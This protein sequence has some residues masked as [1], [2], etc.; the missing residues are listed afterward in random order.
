MRINR[1]LPLLV[2]AVLFPMLAIAQAPLTVG[3]NINMVSGQ[4][5][6]DGDPFLRQQNEPSVA[7]SSRNKLHLLSG[8]NDYRTVD[9]PGDFEA[10][11]TGD[12]WMSYFWSTNGGGTWK[13]RLIPGYPQDSSQEGMASPLKGYAAGAD[14]VVRAG[15]HGMFYFSG[16]VFERTENPGSAIFVSRFID[17]NNDEGGDPIRFIDSML[18]DVD[19]TGDRFLDK[20]WIGVD[21]PR[22]GAPTKT[23]TV[24]QRD[25]STV[26]QTVACGNVYVAYASLTG[27]GATLRSEIKLTYSTDCGDSWSDPAPISEVDTLNQG[28]NIAINPN[29]G[30][31]HIGWRRFD[32]VEAF[33]GTP[34]VSC[35][36]AASEWRRK[37]KKKSVAVE[38]PVE[39]IDLGD[40]RL[41]RDR[42]LDLLDEPNKYKAVKLAK[43]LVASKLNLIAGGGQPSDDFDPAEW[44]RT[45]SELV[46]EAD[47]FFRDNPLQDIPGFTD[48][49]LGRDEKKRSNA[50]R[51]ALEENYLGSPE[52]VATSAADP[53]ETGATNAMVAT[54]STDGGSSFAAPVDIPVP[55]GMEQIRTFDQGGTNFSFRTT[56]YPSLAVDGSGR[57][58]MAFAARG[59]G[60]ARP[61]IDTGDSRIVM[62]ISNDGGNSWQEPWPIDDDINQPGH[63][64]KPALLFAGGKLVV[65]FFDLRA[66]VSGLFEQ[67]V[68]DVPEPD[69]LRHSLDVRAAT[70]VTVAAPADPVFASYDVSDRRDSQQASRYAFVLT[71]EGSGDTVQL[72]YMVPNLPT[73]AGGTQPFIGDYVDVAAKVYINEN[74]V[75]RY[76][77]EPGDV[78]V[79]QAVWTDNRDIV[80]PPD[81][82]WTKYVAPN[83]PGQTGERV[84]VYDGSTIAAC[85]TDTDAELTG[86]RNQN[87]Y[88]ATLS[89]GLIVAA[90]G[91]NK[92]LGTADGTDQLLQRAYVIFVQNVTGQER[93]FRL[94]VAAPAEV[95]ASFE[96]F[97]PKASEEVLVAPYS[98]TVRTVFATSENPDAALAVLVQEIDGATGEVIDSGLASTVLLNAD[99]SAPAPLDNSL[100]FAETYN[101][102][103]LNPTVLNP[104]VLNPTILNPTVLNP[105][106]FNPTVLNP[107]VLNPTVFNPTVLN[108]TVF[109]PTVLNPT[110]F[111]PTV[112]NP[113]VL[114]PTVFNPTVFNPT[115]LNPTVL[116]PTV[117]NPT[118]LNPTVLNPTVLNSTLEPSQQSA[119]VTFTVSNDGSATSSYD[120]DLASAEGA[121][122][123]FS[124][125]VIVYRLNKT[126]VAD[127]CSLVEE[128]QQ[129]LIANVLE[130]ENV[131]DPNGGDGA[132]SFYVEPGQEVYVTVRV[133]PD[134]NS[135][136]PGDPADLNDGNFELSVAV[137]PQAVETV[138][139]IEGETEPEPVTI[140]TP[141]VAPLEIT[142]TAIPDGQLNIPYSTT[143]QATGGVQTP[144]WSLIPSASL[145]SG[146]ALDS[147]GVLSGTPVEPGPIN[148]AVRVTD[149]IQQIDAFFNADIPAPPIVF[150][151]GGL[152]GGTVGANYAGTTLGASGGFGPITYV[153]SG[154]DFPP[155]LSLATTGEITG[156]PTLDGSFNFT[157]DAID[158]FQTESASFNIAVS[159]APTGSL[160]VPNFSFET[161]LPDGNGVALPVG[162]NANGNDGTGGS[163]P[164]EFGF[165][166]AADGN[167][168]LYLNLPGFAGPNPSIA[169]STSFIGNAEVGTYVL[170]V[171]AGRRNNDATTDGSYVIELLA[172]GVVIG[173]STVNDPYNTYAPGTWNDITATAV[174]GTGDPAI[175]QPLSIRLSAFEG[176]P[177]PI[178]SQGQFDN[179][180]LVLAENYTVNDIPPRFYAV[181]Q[182]NPG[183]T[184]REG[185][186]LEFDQLSQTGALI[187]YDGQLGNPIDQGYSWDVIDGRL[188]LTYDTPTEFGSLEFDITNTP[189]TPDQINAFLEEETIRQESITIGLTQRTLATTYT[190]TAN[191]ASVQIVTRED[192]QELIYNPIPLDP[193]NSY[194]VTLGPELTLANK[195][196]I[197]NSTEILRDDSAV[198]GVALSDDCAATDGSVCVPGTWAASYRYLPGFYAYDGYVYPAGN[199]GEMLTFTGG[200]S[201]TVSGEISGGTV[202][203]TWT[204]DNGK[205]VIDYDADDWTQTVTVVENNGVEYGVFNEY[206]N[207]TSGERYASYEIFVKSDGFS[208]N[209]SYLQSQPDRYWN[210]D[211]NSWIPGFLDAN[212]NRTDNARFGWQL[213]AATDPNTG[214]NRSLD[215]FDQDGDGTEEKFLYLRPNEW[216]IQGDGSLKI[217]RFLEPQRDTF[218]RY[219]YPTASVV[220]D[221]ERQM[222]VMEIEYRDAGLGQGL[223]FPARLN[224][225]R[226]IDEL[227]GFE[228]VIIL[229]PTEFVAEEIPPR[230]YEVEDANPGYTSRDGSIMNFVQAGN[231]GSL[232]DIAGPNGPAID[233]AFSWS[234]VNG[235]L[236]VSYSFSGTEDIF[237][238]SATQP[239]LDELQAEG[240]FTIPTTVNSVI[241]YTRSKLGLDFDIAEKRLETTTVYDPVILPSGTL[242]L[243][244][245]VDVEDTSVLLRDSSQVQ[246]LA[247]SDDCGAT[248]GSVCVPGSWGATYRYAPGNEAFFG[249]PIP[250]TSHGDVLTFTSGGSQDVSGVISGVSAS[251]SIAN[252]NLVIDYGDGWTQTATIVENNG[253]EYGVMSEYSNGVESYA[254]YEIFIKADGFG[255][256]DGYLQSQTDRFWNGEINA[257]I[258]GVF[259]ENGDRDPNNRFGWDFD[260]STDPN[261]GFNRFAF[262]TGN[263]EYTLVLRPNEWE[264]EGNGRLRIDRWLD[265]GREAWDRYWYPLASVVVDGERQMYV[266]EIQFLD[267]GLLFPARL[268]IERE[269]L[270][271]D[272]SFWDDIQLETPTSGLISSVQPDPSAAGAG[273]LVLV[274]GTDLP[275]SATPDVFVIQNGVEYTGFDFV[276][277]STDHLVRLPLTG[278]VPGFA[279]IQLSEP[280]AA[281]RTSLYGI[282]ISANPAAPGL[283]GARDAAAPANTV[284]T[285][286]AGGEVA[287]LASATDTVNVTAIFEYLGADTFVGVKSTTVPFGPAGGLL[288][289]FDVPASYPEAASVTISLR[290]QV[291]TNDSAE[292]N[293]VTLTVDS[294]SS[295][296]V[297]SLA[298]AP[299]EDQLV[300]LSGSNLPGSNNPFIRPEV[301]VNQGGSTYTGYVFHFDSNNYLMRMPIDADLDAGAA[302]LQVKAAGAG[303]L[304]SAP[305]PINV[306][307]A[308]GKPI[309]VAASRGGVEGTS[310][311]PGAEI[312]LRAYGI[313][314][315]GSEAFFRWGGNVV[316]LTSGTAS[317]ST[318]LFGIRVPYTAPSGPGLGE[319]TA[320]SVTIRAFANGM[321]SPESD[322]IVLTV[323][324]Q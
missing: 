242:Q 256:T 302:T 68:L 224:I 140:V 282:T 207:A 16:I 149:G 186:I 177:A 11:A 145:P 315:L 230:Y 134:T 167:R 192:D 62:S 98:S 56:A 151:G 106:V 63:Q 4:T 6:P 40:L 317:S 144:S 45:L 9:I 217:D 308:P 232:L 273:Q 251:W 288:H 79:Y 135:P 20:S 36:K 265:T 255:F 150:S 102:T 35:S 109:N 298:P 85:E 12:S 81:G 74:G 92:P 142:T 229:A 48:R 318:P 191:G 138:A 239:Q 69:R 153:V 212:G 117:F 47:E 300:L 44:T 10:G 241:S 234:V 49:K 179:V 199:W 209:D 243:A 42:A 54:V 72:Q 124:Y 169:E 159:P 277:D 290:T 301:F 32:T 139:V 257:W 320:V 200:G 286:V 194:F 83:S 193:S 270:K 323:P 128:A 171:A 219:W 218:D 122:D 76:A 245:R 252:G 285:L 294:Y 39:E 100:L 173:S 309:I 116:N 156:L 111:N 30:D 178:R 50:I 313:D 18:V 2:G 190:L 225:Q 272:D 157:V 247:F 52:C 125:Q 131:L 310:I 291:N 233:Q 38:W 263:D 33:L 77:T 5:W 24:T 97:A 110:V 67:F 197:D 75:W 206:N 7:F 130:P 205:L 299:G 60:S 284:T 121:D 222:Y 322:P 223:L 99:P 181:D 129:E 287:I 71:G 261:T 101:P 136:N 231:I 246:G 34:A 162:W 115:I 105:T 208:F 267:G 113:T 21:M 27:D 253:I 176:T 3:P 170:T 303:E 43:V 127:G 19:T 238:T 174:V 137:T 182:A 214:F 235:E 65:I 120:I 26:S 57:A 216:A 196:E 215:I 160:S 180:R 78:D 236:L 266:M 22:D 58:Y 148:A 132:T 108:P 161:F 133:L 278:L 141:V 280:G 220:A 210:G 260:E 55:D 274:S 66:D 306:G 226:E 154:G 262:S 316:T 96:Q 90:P 227:T 188:V 204:I 146:L 211:I 259:D 59:F 17:L 268:N 51:E 14:P 228:D 324:I 37:K 103:V 202:T 183:Y 163:D 73:H 84:S 104:T 271:L 244:D 319:G 114:N 88:S 119:E 258:P 293:S 123:G 31:V 321:W 82:D 305:F 295:A 168:F 311:Q 213:N 269:I 164:F 296:T 289:I 126:P 276:Y 15:T 80:P 275:T 292:S 189:A 29:N 64:F 95:N 237:N 107:T 250:A 25:G 70:A 89:E 254:K 281:S 158:D 28:A 147:S 175:G 185:V 221:G 143:F 307:A 264:I 203:A 41:S 198:Q 312:S 165:D 152:A 46:T 94:T 61:D 155:G 304:K 283:I 93:I 279:E 118:V 86:T 13:S 112:L 1:L 184:S 91:S 249:P 23:F 314:T 240:I 166:A 248:D 201:Q 297:T 172:G 87:V 187:S 195:T 8:A 53:I